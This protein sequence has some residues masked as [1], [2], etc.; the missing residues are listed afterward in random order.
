[1]DRHTT[2]IQS[3]VEGPTDRQ[4]CLCESNSMNE[5]RETRN[6]KSGNKCKDSVISE[7]AVRWW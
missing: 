7:K 4:S 5:E 3:V 2:I 1:M 6:K